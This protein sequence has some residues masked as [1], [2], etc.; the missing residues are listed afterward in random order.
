MRKS[1]ISLTLVLVLLMTITIP[2]SAIT[3]GQPDGSGHPYGALILVPGMGFCSGT[4]IDEDLVLTA[5]HCTDFFSDPTLNIPAVYVTFDPVAAIDYDT[6]MPL[7]TGT[8]YISTK[9]WVSHPD[10]VDS[11]W[12][13]TW[14]YGLVMLD[15]DVVGITPASLPYLG[16][17]DVLVGTTG[18]T[19]QRFYDVG[20]GQNGV[21][22][23]YQP[24]SANFDFTRRVAEQR[25]I[26]SKGSVGTQDPRWLMLN[27]V[28]SAKHGSGCG[29]DSGS[30]IFIN[31]GAYPATVVA[32]HTGGYNLGWKNQLCGRITSLNHRVDLPEVLNWILPYM[33]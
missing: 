31:K 24:Y 23:E 11:A 26:P 20:Y 28:P 3:G 18:Q 15:E 13:F 29:G 32:V 21:N 22:K 12:P 27:N 30:G 10:Y 1:L 17:V 14:D 16:M 4:L 5:G 8:W 7:T 25:Y 19:N 6:W 2:A 33:D 9:S